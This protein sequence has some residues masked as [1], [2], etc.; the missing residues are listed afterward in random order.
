MSEA[1]FFATPADFRDWLAAHHERERELVVGFYKK[2]SGKASITWPESVDE[3]LC[4]GWIDSVRRRLDDESYSIR[5]TPRQARSRWSTVNIARVEELTR[6]GRMRPAGLEAFRR[7]TEEQSET[8]AYEQRGELS[9][10]DAMVVQFRLQTEAW[11]FFQAQAPWY[12]KKATWWVMSAKRDTTRQRR[13]DRLITLSAAN[14]R[15]A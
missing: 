14:E 12:R 1:V 9:L 6:E 2:G 7:R 3:A 10:D 15:L 13:L 4:F 11:S 8:Y 5:F